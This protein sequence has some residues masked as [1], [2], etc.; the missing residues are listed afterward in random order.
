MMGFIR[1]VKYYCGD[2]YLETEL[3]E[4]PN[5][6][7]RGKPLR[8]KKEKPSTPGKAKWNRKNAIRKFRQKVRRLLHDFYLLDGKHARNKGRREKRIP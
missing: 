8:R 6:N 4:M 7:D 3:F 5:M 2:E 1:N